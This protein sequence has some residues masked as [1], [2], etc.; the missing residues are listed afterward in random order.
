MVER[1]NDEVGI[2]PLEF[3]GRKK[4]HH[5]TVLTKGNRRERIK[6]KLG[7][8]LV[9]IRQVGGKIELMTKNPLSEGV[10]VAVEKIWRR[11]E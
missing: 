5:M 1:P 3:D 2:N 6:A 11:E 9:S 8:N 10:R 7:E 4:K